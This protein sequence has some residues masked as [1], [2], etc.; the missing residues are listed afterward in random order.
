MKCVDTI[1]RIRREFFV[2]GKTI[3]EIVREL[4]VSRNTVRKVVRSGATPFEYERER[5]PRPPPPLSA[6][7]GT[8]DVSG[9]TEENGE[10]M[11]SWI[12]RGGPTVEHTSVRSGYG[13]KLMER[14]ISN[15]LGG[16]I[17]YEWASDGLI[18]V[19]RMKAERL[20]E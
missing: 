2:R 15:Q 8:L 12:E 10:I 7:T 14:S 4:H 18:V 3:K 6:D 20:A 19:L 13:T 16:S 9:S 1:A 11:I 17:A 5:Q